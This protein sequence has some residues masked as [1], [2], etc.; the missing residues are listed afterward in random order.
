MRV[1]DKFKNKILKIFMVIVHNIIIIIIIIIIA[2][3][4]QTAYPITRL[5][6][7]MRSAVI[8]ITT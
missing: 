7:A 1:I 6:L 8:C 3:T 5:V 2:M 4:T